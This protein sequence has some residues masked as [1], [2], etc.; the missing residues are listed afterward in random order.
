MSNVASPAPVAAP[1]APATPT[2]QDGQKD[3][4]PNIPD[5]PKFKHKDLELDAEQVYS[6]VKRARSAGKVITETQRRLEESNRR[7][8]EFEAAKKR[9]REN[10]EEA[11]RMLGLEGDEGL[12]VLGKL[13]YDKKI[14]PQK[15]TEEQR[16]I[17]DLERKLAAQEKDKQ[18][19]DQA[20]KQQMQENLQTETIKKVESEILAKIKD[21]GLPNHPGAL[22]E[23][24]G[25]WLNYLK[26]GVEISLDDAAA[27]YG[28]K[29]RER[30]NR[31]AESFKTPED[32]EKYFGPETMKKLSR[33][34]YQWGL[35]QMTQQQIQQPGTPAPRGSGEVMKFFADDKKTDR[36]Y[37]S[38]QE[39]EAYK[40][41]NW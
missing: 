10:P 35:K 19:Q 8:Q 2:G 9:V 36:K 4:K 38:P 13:L 41:K 6:E 34:F 26:N 11:F 28:A 5:P 24:A 21:G 20:R 33:V 12:D 29:E 27:I 40:R 17:A 30:I 25:E 18:S 1:S 31:V 37:I 32:A 3:S 14:A 7:S 15:M 23:I 39:W 22:H 16:R